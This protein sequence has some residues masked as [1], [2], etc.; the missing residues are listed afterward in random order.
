MYN[1]SLHINQFNKMYVWII[2]AV[3]STFL[4]ASCDNSV[5]SFGSDEQTL[6]GSQDDIQSTLT[7]SSANSEESTDNIYLTDV[8]HFLEPVSSSNEVMGE[9]DK[10][11]LD[12]LTVTVCIEGDN[13]T[14][15]DELNS[16]SSGREQLRLDND[17]VYMAT[18]QPSGNQ[19]RRGSQPSEFRI[20]VDI[21]GLVIAD[22]SV[23]IKNRGQMNRAWPVRFLIENDAKIRV[24]ALT[25]RGYSS[26][27]IAEVLLAE[28]GLDAFKA[29]ELLANDLA[30]FNANQIAE[31]LKS[32]YEQS[33]DETAHIL[34]RVQFNVYETTEALHQ[35]F[36]IGEGL[37][38]V[39]L[40]YA[41]FTVYEI[42]SALD[43][44]LD[45]SE[46]AIAAA[47]KLLILPQ[48][49]SS[50]RSIKF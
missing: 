33:A 26:T 42:T 23:D 25:E 15:P 45:L 28:F 39:A 6:S 9:P 36:E 11:L 8:F 41:G 48:I 19:N 31:A 40:D 49:R 3:T 22:H 27:E 29:A 37:I 44:T 14:S 32:V 2:I 38:S 30:P 4:L 43:Q 20:M 5:S 21:A 10:S 16:G 18:W 1:I 34:K 46:D 13:C 35:I 24:R 12:L 50:V 17:G 47:L 7:T